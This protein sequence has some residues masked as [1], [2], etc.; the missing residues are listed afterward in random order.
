MKKVLFALML[1]SLAL[2]IFGCGANKKKVKPDGNLVYRP[3]W[4]SEQ[5]DADYVCAYGQSVNMNENASL[6]AARSIAMSEAAQYVQ[7]NVESMMKFYLEEAGV[8]DPQLLTLTSNVVRVSAKAEFS[9]AI[10][11][12]VETRKVNEGNGPRFKSWVQMKIPKEQIDKTVW[13]GIRNEEALYNQFKASQS[14]QELDKQMKK[15][16]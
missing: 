7:T 8:V 4:W 3:T 9:G 2:V 11:G 1:L 16:E 14:F 15:F 6:T 5:K 13:Q 12:K 10:N